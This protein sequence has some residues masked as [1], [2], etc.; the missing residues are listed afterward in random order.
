MSEIIPPELWR[1]V[2]WEF[3]SLSMV[4]QNKHVTSGATLIHA[5]CWACMVHLNTFNIKFDAKPHEGPF[6]YVMDIPNPRQ[7]WKLSITC[8]P[9][10]CT[11]FV[12]F[13]RTFRY[14]HFHF[15]EGGVLII[16]PICERL[17]RREQS[18]A[19]T[20]YEALRAHFYT[21]GDSEVHRCVTTLSANMYV[22]S[23]LGVTVMSMHHS[24]PP[25]P[26]FYENKRCDTTYFNES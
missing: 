8:G 13:H 22:A 24:L 26:F 11:I 5:L 16:V 17:S 20:A 7:S 21:H 1:R 6:L 2:F 14:F 19:D 15:A 25:L 18:L 23:S 4:L 12:V 3:L 9:L 10:C